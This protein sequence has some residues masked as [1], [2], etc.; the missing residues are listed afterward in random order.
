MEAFENPQ[1][2]EGFAK[3]LGV[4]VCVV[5][6]ALATVVTLIHFGSDAEEVSTGTSSQGKQNPAQPQQQPKPSGNKSFNF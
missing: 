3:M 5:M 2:P 4:I 1:K 6:V